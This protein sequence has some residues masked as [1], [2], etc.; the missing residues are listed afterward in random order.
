MLLNQF[1]TF[2]AVCRVIL[3]NKFVLLKTKHELN[4][5]AFNVNY[6]SQR[7][8]ICS[9]LAEDTKL[10]VLRNK[11]FGSVRSSGCHSVCLSVRHKFV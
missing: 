5:A 6:G 11:F 4:L 7:C 8:S 1:S 10:P 2:G 3:R 9:L